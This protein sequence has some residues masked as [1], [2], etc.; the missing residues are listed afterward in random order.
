[1]CINQLPGFFLSFFFFSPF[2]RER[3]VF[4]N[5]AEW[6][7]DSHTLFMDMQEKSCWSLCLGLEEWA[8]TLLPSQV[9]ERQG[10]WW[11][12]AS[13]SNS[14]LPSHSFSGAASNPGHLYWEH[15]ERACAFFPASPLGWDGLFF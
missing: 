14:Y 13:D 1:M 8:L 9:S 4:G 5:E 12:G 10:P 11:L 15:I 2:G 7:L 3:S 6:T